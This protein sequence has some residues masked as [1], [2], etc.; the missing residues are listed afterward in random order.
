MLKN[1]DKVTALLRFLN[2]GLLLFLFFAIIQF[3]LMYS[4][5]EFL[6]ILKQY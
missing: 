4:L 6:I 2:F 1:N 3:N 5:E